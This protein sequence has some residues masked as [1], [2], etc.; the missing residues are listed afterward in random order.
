MEP[1]IHVGLSNVFRPAHICRR[2]ALV[3]KNRKTRAKV[4]FLSGRMLIPVAVDVASQASVHGATTV[5]YMAN[6]GSGVKKYSASLGKQKPF[7][8]S[9]KGKALG[10]TAPGQGY[11]LLLDK[12]LTRVDISDEERR[13]IREARGARRA[14]SSGRFA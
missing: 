8:L 13:A 6:T 5:K 4:L 12:G 2:P 3:I 14:F 7:M 1:H 9:A 11:V 10:L